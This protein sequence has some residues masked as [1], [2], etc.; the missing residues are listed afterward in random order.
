MTHRTDSQAGFSLLETLL[1]LTLTAIIGMLMMASF[2]MGARVWERDRAPS[3]LGVD[4]LVLSQTAEWLSQAMP[5]KVR[6][7]EDPAYTPFSGE[8]TRVTFEFASPAMGGTP[9]IYEVTLELVQGEACPQQTDLM[10][11]TVRLAAVESD[12]APP[13]IPVDSRR[14][15]ACVEGASFVFWDALAND[16]SSAWRSDWREQT[17]LPGLVRLRTIGADGAERAIL[18]QRLAFAQR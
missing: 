2:Q 3:K 1:G 5:A 4:Q 7:V 11:R 10:L 8:P 14:L 12:E 9:G 13:Q 16:T 18:T 15:M 17:Y 6:S